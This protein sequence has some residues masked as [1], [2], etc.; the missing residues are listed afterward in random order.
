[1]YV[2]QTHQQT[3]WSLEAYILGNIVTGPKQAYQHSTRQAIT[4]PAGYDVKIR[5]PLDFQG[6]TVHA[7]YVG[8][9]RSAN[10]KPIG[11]LLD[12]TIINSVWASNNEVVENI[13]NPANSRRSVPMNGHPRRRTGTCIAMCSFRTVQK[14]P[15]RP[16]DLWNWMGELRKTG[17]EALAISHN[18]NLSNGIM[19]PIEIDSKGKPINA[20]SAQQRMLNKPPTEL[21]QV[22]GASDTHPDPSPND[23]FANFEIMNYLIGIDNSFSK[24][25]GSYIREA[26]QNGLA[27]QGFDAVI[28][29]SPASWVQAARTPQPRHMPNRI[30]LAITG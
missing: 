22:E 12:P 8:I 26:F 7:E 11:A 10:N 3:S 19:F 2:G 6:V 25:Y 21:K 20:A 18:S 15:K 1:M 30:S 28:S 24:I 27:L 13:T 4:H 5:T 29:I 16:E 9:M 17:N 14:C 23:E